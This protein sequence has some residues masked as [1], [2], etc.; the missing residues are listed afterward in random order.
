M[1]FLPII[2]HP[3]TLA[4]TLLLSI[5]ILVIYSSS[6]TLAFQQISFAIF[7]FLMF[8]LVSRFDYRLL[9]NIS[10]AA[11]LI[12]IILLVVV[13]FLGIE[14]RGSVRWISLGFLNIQPSELAKPALILILASLWTK[15]LP[16]WKNIGLSF[17]I[18]IPVIFLV[19][20]Q[21]DL[22]SA[23]TIF[24]IWM[25]MLIPAQVSLKKILLI[26]LILAL[27]TPIAWFSLENYQ[28][29]RIFSFL[30]PYE[31]PLGIGYNIIQSTISVGSG[32]LMGRGLGHGTQSRLQ[33]LP[34]S[35]TDFIYAFIAEE[36]GFLGAMIIMLLHFFLIFFC[37]RI[38]EKSHDKFGNLIIF[39]VVSMLFFQSFVNIGMN[40][41]ILPITGITLPLV[42]YG[43]SSLIATMICLGF[44]V[45]IDKLRKRIDIQLQEG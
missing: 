35:R 43:G 28:K 11:Y 4:S 21:P 19:F 2:Y 45:S 36:L 38:A 10:T 30:S 34:E 37:L 20:E 27:L 29:Q 42:S 31:D 33:F 14:T 15:N 44:I 23:L 40:A 16:T 3:L 18:S 17:L 32:Q 6:T 1:G 41:G 25:G 24:A 8:F 5:S 7:G 22:G 12:I 9:K 13:L 39:G 26:T